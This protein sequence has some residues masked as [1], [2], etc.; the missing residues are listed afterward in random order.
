MTNRSSANSSAQTGHSK[1]GFL[2]LSLLFALL[3]IAAL[4]FLALRLIPPYSSNSQ[5]QDAVE[6]LASRATYSQMPESEIRRAVFA[7]PVSS[8]S[9]SKTGR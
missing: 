3:F 6:N 1:R 4:I 5:L 9:N 2:S 8:A 7:G